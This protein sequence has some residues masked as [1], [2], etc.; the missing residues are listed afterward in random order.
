MAGIVE[1]S[2]QGDTIPMHYHRETEELQYIVSGSGVV[3]DNEGNEY[4]VEAGTAVYCGA[5]SQSAHEFENTE[6]RPL[7]VLFIYPSLGG[8]SPDVSWYE[9]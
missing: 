7:I 3:R 6:N 5:G 4:P 2:S 8:S 9:E 1:L